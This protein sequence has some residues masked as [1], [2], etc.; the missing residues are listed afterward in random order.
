MPTIQSKIAKH[1]KKTENVNNSWKKS[2]LKQTM[3]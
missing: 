1:A 3:K 2:Q